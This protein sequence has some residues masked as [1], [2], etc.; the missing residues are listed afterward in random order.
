[1]ID[2]S[3]R[4]YLIKITCECQKYFRG[5]EDTKNIDEDIDMTESIYS[6]HLYTWH[7]AR[8]KAMMGQS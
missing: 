6:G 3:I 8:M 5:R 2:V 1:M 7:E 4:M